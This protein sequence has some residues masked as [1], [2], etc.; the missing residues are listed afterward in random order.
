MNNTFDYRFEGQ[1]KEVSPQLVYYPALIR[2]NIAKMIKMA[3]SPER[4]WPHIKTHK[5][6]YVVKMQME[7]GITRFK[8]ATIAEAEMAARA[9]AEHLLIAYPLVGPNPGR[10]VTLK[11]MFPK[12]VFYAI[13]DDT[14]QIQRLGR[15]ALEE[16][17]CVNV[18]MDMDTGQHRTGVPMEKAVALYR[19]WASFPGVTM[20]GMH[21]YDGQ[22]HESDS[23]VR[24]DAVEKVDAVL[25]ALK[26]QLEEDGFDCSILVMGGTPSFPAHISLTEEYLS[27]GTCVIQDAG[28]RDAYQDM[29]FVPAA[30]VMS[31]VVSRPGEDTFTLD[32]GTKAVASDPPAERGE[33]VGMEYAKTVLQ[34]EEHWVVKVPQEHVADIPKIGSEVFV[35][36]T[37]VCPTSALYPEVLAVEDKKL[38]GRWPV[39][40][41]N[42]KLTI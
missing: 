9:G 6:A 12:T 27:P 11:K 8:C 35:I 39:E 40:A 29:D 33:I 41:R 16:G 30:C 36:P 25:L 10:F 37:H 34:N 2:D 31:R 3:G 24:W 15:I 42:R 21:C 4:L 26:K 5:N 17:M 19:E 23:R 13:G 7:A 32:M 28:Y 38:I 22:R 1:E 14:E 20:C 18:L